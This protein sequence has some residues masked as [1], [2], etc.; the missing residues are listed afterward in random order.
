MIETMPKPNKQNMLAPARQRMIQKDL[1][2][3]D[4]TDPDVLRVM[5]EV[6]REAFVPE[7][8][9][10]QAYADRPIPFV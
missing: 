2:G 1:R 7:Q 9:R 3:R 6:R 5:A 10:H 8:Y 4:I